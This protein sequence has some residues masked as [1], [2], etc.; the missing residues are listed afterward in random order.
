MNASNTYIRTET[1]K[2]ALDQAAD[3]LEFYDAEFATR[4]REAILAGKLEK[5][6][7]FA[8]EFFIYGEEISFPVPIRCERYSFGYGE[9]HFDLKWNETFGLAEWYWTNS[10]TR[11]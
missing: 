6:I 5:N 9:N 7:I 10:I 1:L 8:D 11:Y 2:S 4:L 3:T